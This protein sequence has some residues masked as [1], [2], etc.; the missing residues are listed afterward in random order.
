VGAQGPEWAFSWLQRAI[1]AGRALWFYAW[2]LLWP[3]NLS[4]AY[5]RWPINMPQQSWQML[6]GVAAIAVI[7]VLFAFRRRLGRAPVVAVAFFVVTVFPALGFVN[8][9]S[10]RY[11]FTADRYQYLA[12]LG[13]IALLV[14][15]VYRLIAIREVAIPVGGIIVLVLG[16][17]TWR[18]ARNYRNEFALWNDTL[19]VSP[20]SWIARDRFG[21][22]LLRANRDDEALEQFRIARHLNP[23][24]AEVMSHMG[25]VAERRGDFPNA[26]KYFLAAVDQAARDGV[27][28]ANYAEPFYYLGRIYSQNGRADDAMRAYEAAIEWNPFHSNAMNTLGVLYA[29]RHEFD[30]AI[31]LYTHSLELDPDAVST[32]TNLG[33]AY[34]QKGDIADAIAQWTEV[35]RLDPDNA[36]VPNGLGLALAHAGK[37]DDA[38][39]MF[40]LALQRNPNLD[41]ARRNLEAAQRNRK[42]AATRPSTTSTSTT[43][44]ATHP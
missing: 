42:L 34:L 25:L 20:D 23:R 22:I 6:F 14:P 5:Q 21:L 1:I 43:I 17:L 35:L 41:A 26:E 15:L 18:Q 44:P 12:C 2:K 36:N 8:I 30:R 19:A 4:I 28:R 3:A 24:S 40:N 33:N 16:V 9:Y 11:A 38:I 39:K 37:W 32:R 29:N 10:L 27:P 31:E 13:L 7:G